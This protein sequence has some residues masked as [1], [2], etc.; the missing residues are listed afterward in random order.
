SG[1]DASLRLIGRGA[2]QFEALAYGSLRDFNN[3]TISATTALPTLNQRTTPSSGIG[4]KLELR[5]PVGG[6]H[7]LRLGADW[8]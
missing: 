1:Q 5:P 8:R 4:A 7:V 2:W 6:G 3:L